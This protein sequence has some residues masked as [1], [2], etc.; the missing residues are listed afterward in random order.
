MKANLFFKVGLP[1]YTNFNESLKPFAESVTYD[2]FTKENIFVFNMNYVDV[3]KKILGKQLYFNHEQLQKLF[4]A[5]PESKKNIFIKEEYSD[6]LMKVFLDI[7]T[8]VVVH[9]KDKQVRGRVPKERIDMLWDILNKYPVMKYVKTTTIE[10]NWCSKLGFSKFF[11]K[12]GK[13]NKKLFSGSRAEYLSFYFSLKVVQAM[14]MIDYKKEGSVARL[15]DGEVKHTDLEL[16]FG[17]GDETNVL[18][19]NG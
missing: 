19:N 10:K 4:E 16:Y 9:E 1:F 6:G 15:K 11:K 2:S 17:K 8:Y 7:D 14:G 18:E 12:N 13:F 5:Y 3:V